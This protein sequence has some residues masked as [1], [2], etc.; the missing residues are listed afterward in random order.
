MRDGH[1]PRDWYSTCREP[2]FVF[3]F[4]ADSALAM[5]LQPLQFPE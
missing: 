4:A 3:N 2:G 5:G 1:S